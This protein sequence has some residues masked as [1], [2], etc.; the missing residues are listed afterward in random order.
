MIRKIFISILLLATVISCTTDD[1]LL[2]VSNGKEQEREVKLRL[3]FSGFKNATMTRASYWGDYGD[4]SDSYGFS[5][6][7]PFVYEDGE[8]EPGDQ[9]G[10]YCLDDNSVSPLNLRTIGLDENADVEVEA[11]DV[12]DDVFELDGKLDGNK[13]YVIFYPYSSWNGSSFMMYDGYA[14][15]GEGIIQNY[16]FSNVF[17]GDDVENIE[18]HP[19]SA[20][21]HL[22][23][24]A[25]KRSGLSKEKIKSV[26]VVNVDGDG[27]FY[28]YARGYITPNGIDVSNQSNASHSNCLHHYFREYVK[29]NTKDFRNY[30]ISSIQTKT[31]RFVLKATTTSGTEYYSEIIYSSLDLKAGH[32]YDIVCEKW[33]KTKPDFMYEDFDMTHGIYYVDLGVPNVY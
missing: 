12:T 7:H 19:V 20:A 14:Y 5:F 25:D 8:V 13:R 27:M 30:N 33:T 28:F 16:Y 21:L 29:L 9:F 26:D 1:D 2:D 22:K 18:L 31:G 32:G 24:K 4:D 11:C 15:Q 17:I 3:R 23:L 10:L 6:D